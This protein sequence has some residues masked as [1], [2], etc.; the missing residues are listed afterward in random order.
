[1]VSVKAKQE[2]VHGK[3]NMAKGGSADMPEQIAKE[4]SEA[5][6]VTVGQKQAPAPENKM[7]AEPKNK[8]ADSEP[9]KTITTAKIGKKQK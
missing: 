1:M 2:F 9:S 3:W 6:L 8:S 5:G 4:L 7:A